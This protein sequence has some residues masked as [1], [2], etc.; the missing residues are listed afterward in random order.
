PGRDGKSVETGLL[1]SWPENGPRRLWTTEGLGAGY[2]SF[3]VEG[4]KLFT[5][6]QRSGRQY[7]MAFDT[8]N[9]RKLWEVENGR[10]YM[11]GRGDGPRGTPTVDGDGV[12]AISGNGNVICTEAATGKVIW[13]LDMLGE[14]G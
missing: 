13:Q 9:G 2:S 11:D 5:Q 1:R 10:Q 6:G 8:S 7:L 12:Y 3:A 14:F 4:G